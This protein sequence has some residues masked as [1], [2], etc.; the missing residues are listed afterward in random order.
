MAVDPETPPMPPPPVTGYP[1]QT[2]A[3]FNVVR[4][5]QIIRSVADGDCHFAYDRPGRRWF[6][7]TS[8]VRSASI[9]AKKNA[10][11]EN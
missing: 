6:R 1:H 2:T 9:G 7:R 3:I 11:R 4:S 10:E 5:V 8:I